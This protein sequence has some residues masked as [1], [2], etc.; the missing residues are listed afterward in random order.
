VKRIM[1]QDTMGFWHYAQETYPDSAETRCGLHVRC[2]TFCT[3]GHPNT[4]QGE[5]CVIC[6][7]E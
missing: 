3:E 4:Q 7:T 2:A 1:V 5:R 6:F